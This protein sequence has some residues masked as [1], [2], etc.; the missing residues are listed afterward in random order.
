MAKAYS[1]SL[2]E[3]PRRRLYVLVNGTFIYGLTHSHLWPDTLPYIAWHTPIYGLT[4]SHIWP[5]TL[6]L[7]VPTHSH[8]WPDTL[9]SM[10]WHTP[11][12]GLTQIG[13]QSRVF[14]KHGLARA[15]QKSYVFMIFIFLGI[16]FCNL[17]H[18]DLQGVIPRL[19]KSLIGF[20]LMIFSINSLNK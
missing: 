7:H 20:F 16:F 11:I 13:I 3:G 18:S 10:A 14:N 1:Q 15:F 19:I 17:L 12:Y 6:P 9:P 8:L 2:E 5:D 4:H